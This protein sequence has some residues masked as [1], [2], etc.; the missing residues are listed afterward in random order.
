M[1]HVPIKLHQLIV[2][3]ELALWINPKFSAGVPSDR[4]CQ[5]R[6][7]IFPINME[8]A[9]EAAVD[10]NRGELEVGG[11]MSDEVADML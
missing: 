3:S 4:D 5:A 10:L 9:L 11:M 8:H 1:R 6:S 2:H 7:H